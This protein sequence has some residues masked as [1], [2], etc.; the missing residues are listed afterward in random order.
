[1]VQ[2][3]EE[4]KGTGKSFLEFITNFVKDSV[5]EPVSRNEVRAAS[6]W[7]LYSGVIGYCDPYNNGCEESVGP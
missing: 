1:M 4:K 3:A 5:K 7:L 2:M 6:S